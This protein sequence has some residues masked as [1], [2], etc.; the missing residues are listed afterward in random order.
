VNANDV[1]STGGV[2]KWFLPTVLLPEGAPVETAVHIFNQLKEAAA[3]LGVTLVGGHTE[4]T[5]GLPRPLVCGTMLGEARP[6][7][8]VSTGG[9]APGDDVILTKGIAI[10]GTSLLAREMRDQLL[11]GGVSEE[12]LDR[13]S[14]YLFKP[15]ISV[16]KEARAA[17]GAGQ[18]TSMHDPTEGGLATALAEVAEA[19]GTGIEIDEASVPL[20]DEC[21]ELCG[22]LGVDPWGLISSGALLI[23]CHP[24]S[25]SG[26]VS[27][28]GSL[29]ITV[30]VIGNVT[31]PGQGLVLRRTDGEKTPLPV[32]AR[33]E[34]ARLF[35]E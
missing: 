34:I 11:A 3:S 6:S 5:T 23:T 29:G 28:I 12:T 32:F 9:A 2:P 8:T 21:R 20:L 26:I 31:E 35:E 17:L 4:I 14:N 22:V 7:E 25:T 33:D 10:E 13:A 27:A 19:S 16:V 24:D 30:S 15:G 18:V 1:A